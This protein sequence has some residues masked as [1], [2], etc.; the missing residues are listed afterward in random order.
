M[1][2]KQ[3]PINFGEGTGSGMGAKRKSDLSDENLKEELNK[4][5][6][7]E[8]KTELS[9]RDRRTNRRIKRNVEKGNLTKAARISN[10]AADR[11]RRKGGKTK[12]APT[13]IEIN[14]AEAYGGEKGAGKGGPQ[15]QVG[16]NKETGEKPK[17]HKNYT[18]RT[19][20]QTKRGTGKT[21]EDVWATASDS[22]K[23]KYGGDKAKAISAMK[24][25]NKKQDAKKKKANP[26][27][28]STSTAVKENKNKQK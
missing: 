19:G 27:P 25:W 18:E 13:S 11:K 14:S 24:A 9:W 16:K 15:T 4:D 8:E 5:K 3:S 6:P 28:Y 20:K 2:Y 21:Y 12:V 7:K 10:N 26:S 22:Y 1:G 23:A 17:E